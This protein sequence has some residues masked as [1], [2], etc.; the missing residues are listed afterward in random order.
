YLYSGQKE[1]AAALYDRAIA[2]CFK[3]YQ[4]NPRDAANLGY[5]ALYYARKSDDA[6]A[7]D[8][9]R[10][11][12]SINGN[13][14]DLIYKEAIIHTIAGKQV[15]AIQSLREA[16]QKGYTPEEAKNDPD[17]RALRA[18]PEFNRLLQEFSRKP[19]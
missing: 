8:Y 9:I 2:L 7:I 16:F 6:R 19:N 5:L 4:V 10:R 11:A 17:L 12:R 13:D 15:E 1:K 3:A 18:I 14:S